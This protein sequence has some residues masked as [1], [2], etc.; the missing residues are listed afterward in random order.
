VKKLLAGIVLGLIIG[1]TG[2]ALARA[3]RF[4]Y[5]NRGDVAVGTGGETAC[6]AA[7][8]AGSRLGFVCRVGGDYRAA[9]GVIINEREAAITQYM[10]FNRY[11]VLIRKVQ[12]P[13]P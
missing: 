9:Y 12:H 6:T 11:R 8:H 7:P 3:D 13:I 10:G 2:T 4:V 5:L 1:A